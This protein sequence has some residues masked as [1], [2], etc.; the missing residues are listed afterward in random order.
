MTR[1]TC[2]S[3][4]P[5]RRAVRGLALLLAALSASGCSSFGLDRYFGGKLA[6]RVAV[7]PDLNDLSPVAVELLIVYD[8]KVLATL[9]QM[10]AEQWFQ[11]RDQ[12]L[13]QYS[14]AKHELDHW[15]WEWV[16][17]QV[18]PQQVCKYGIGA[19]GALI[20]ADYFSPGAHR[21]SVDPFR[22]LLVNLGADGFTVQSL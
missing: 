6:V 21:A 18:V 9:Q 3:P 1:S 4:R 7:A 14:Q 15:K 16:P 22:P 5:G 19:R 13:Q 10:T 12:L 20:F 11:Q 17:G 2:R 8:K